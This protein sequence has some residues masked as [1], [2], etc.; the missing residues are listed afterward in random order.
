MPNWSRWKAID[1]PDDDAGKRRRLRRA[2]RSNRRARA[3]AT[4]LRRDRD[5]LRQT[6]TAGQVD[7]AEIRPKLMARPPPPAPWL[8]RVG[9]GGLNGRCA[10]FSFA[11]GLD[12]ADVVRDVSGMRA[13]LGRPQRAAAYTKCRFANARPEPVFK[14]F[15]KAI[16][17]ASVAKSRETTS[18]HGRSVDVCRDPPALCVASRDPT[19]LVS[20][21]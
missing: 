9:S 16:A 15:S 1:A 4:R 11:R 5:L 18:A 17:L 21:T 2:G 10:S 20:P 8:L 13:H 3:Q 19:S 12:T 7:P 6:A 14:Y